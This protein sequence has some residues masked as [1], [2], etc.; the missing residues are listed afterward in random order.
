MTLEDIPDVEGFVRWR[1]SKLDR[2]F[3]EQ[4]RADAVAEGMALIYELREHWDPERCP[5][6]SAYA[7]TYLQCRLLDWW[8]RELRQSGKGTY[9]SEGGYEYRGTVPLDQIELIA[10][11]TD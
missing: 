9:S 3:T 5:R 7:L 4:E 6:F 1:V 10:H 2:N 8:R 11:A